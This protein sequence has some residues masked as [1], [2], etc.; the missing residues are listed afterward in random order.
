[1]TSKRLKEATAYFLEGLALV[2][3]INALGL[4]LRFASPVLAWLARHVWT[5]ATVLGVAEP[6]FSPS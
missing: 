2:V 5:V 1:M 3:A 6:H 4:L